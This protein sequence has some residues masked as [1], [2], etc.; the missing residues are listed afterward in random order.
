[1]GENPKTSFKKDQNPQEV[2]LLLGLFIS[3][4]FINS[5]QTKPFF[6]DYFPT[7]RLLPGPLFKKK[8][9]C[10][11][12]RAS[13]PQLLQIPPVSRLIGRSSWAKPCR[14]PG[15]CPVPRGVARHLRWIGSG[16]DRFSGGLWDS[17]QRFFEGFYW[18]KLG[19]L[20]VLRRKYRSTS[21]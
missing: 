3:T 6:E 11:A 1:M 12:F 20:R 18:K 19:F 9:V 5:L 15:V 16:R 17:K 14:S 4:F 7:W 8:T 2:T 13:L 21:V 10:C